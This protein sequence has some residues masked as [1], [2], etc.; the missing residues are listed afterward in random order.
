M[1]QIEGGFGKNSIFNL[2]G[3]FIEAA[4]SITIKS[5]SN[6]DRKNKWK[7]VSG[8]EFYNSKNLHVIMYDI[9]GWMLCSCIHRHDLALDVP[10]S[11]SI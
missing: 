7:T 1:I 9:H 3:Y 6:R 10:E 11:Y 2:G 8:S 4:A 5:P